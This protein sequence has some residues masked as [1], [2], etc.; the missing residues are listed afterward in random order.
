MNKLLLGRLLWGWLE[1]VVSQ[2]VVAVELCRQQPM[3]VAGLGR[4][5]PG[6]WRWLGQGLEGVER[7]RRGGFDGKK[8]FSGSLIHMVLQCDLIDKFILITL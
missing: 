8:H 1:N 2:E 4:W 5:A 6:W 7:M 3:M